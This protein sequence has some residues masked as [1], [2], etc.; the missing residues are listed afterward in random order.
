MISNYNESK[1]PFE[2]EMVDY[3]KYIGV[4][5][6]NVLAVNPTN[7][8]LRNYGW[9]IPED[10]DERKYVFVKEKDGKPSSST[11]ITILVQ[12]QDLEDKPIVPMDF[13]IGPEV[14]VNGNG[15]KA[16]VIDDFGRTA[17]ATKDE[18]QAKKIPQYANGP[19]SISAKYR[20]CHRGEEELTRFIFKYLNI[21]PLQRFDRTLNEY[22]DTKNPGSFSFDNW[23]QLCN[24]NVKELEGYFGLQPQN[25]VK[26]IFGVT[27]TEDNKTY[28]TFL[29]TNYLG[30]SNRPDKSSGYYTAAQ[31]AIKK[32]T[33]RFPNGNDTFSAFPVKLWGVTAT[34]Q[35]EDN[36]GTMFDN[37]GNFLDDLPL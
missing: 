20:L 1:N 33:E 4:A 26:V 18:I 24:G 32:Y 16:Q 5:S 19:A 12:I 9:S 15:D 28:Q 34:E 10:A 36:S 31:N 17:W 27:T 8:V 35:V 29:N 22:V 7:D 6:V 21:T 2:G 11:K 30:N 13:W 3:K 25:R 23:K 14:R 37:D